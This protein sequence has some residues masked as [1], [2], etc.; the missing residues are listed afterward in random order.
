[1]AKPVS[2]S[3]TFGTQASPIPLSYLDT[4]YTQLTGALNDSVTY[5]NFL[6]D[7]GTA[8]T[9]VV[10]FPGSVTT[11][12]TAGL[13]I[14]V[15]IA[16]TNTG[17]STINVNSLGTKNIVNTNG[18]ALVAGQL[19]ANG[20]ALLQ[21]DG[22]SFQ[23][24]NDPSAGQVLPSPLPVSQGGTGISTVPTNGQLLIG[25]GT[26]YTAANLTAGSGALITNAAGSI[27]IATTGATGLPT[28]VLVSATTVTAV[29]G[30][31][32][33]LSNAAAS[34]LTL[35]ATPSA[36][37][38]VWVTGANGLS[39]NIVNPGSEKIQGATGN[40]TLAYPYSSFQFR[41]IT[42]TMG[43]AVI[44]WGPFQVGA[45]DYILESYGIT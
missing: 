7:I 10:N 19:P 34:T 35:P 13:L 26:N 29:S 18:S 17:A 38:L 39:T 42:S 31:H 27:T 24:L 9:Y 11:S 8:N 12:Y 36:G 5:S 6:V 41:Y 14:Q 20:I 1:M 32:Y 25:N 15:A 45:Q 2:L 3:Y 23:L 22:A 43:W 37:D 16:N 4:N 44:G 40:Y 30:A 28:F 21:Y 33:A